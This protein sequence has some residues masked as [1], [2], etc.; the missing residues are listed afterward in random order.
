VRPAEVRVLLL[1]QLPE[2]RARSSNSSCS[3]R[4]FPFEFNVKPVVCLIVSEREPKS[5]AVGEPEG[6]CLQAAT[7]TLG[8]LAGVSRNLDNDKV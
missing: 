5:R 8:A 4:G 2:K 3:G 7:P 6:L 1:G